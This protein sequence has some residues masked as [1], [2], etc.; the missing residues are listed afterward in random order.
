[1]SKVAGWRRGRD[2]KYP[3]YDHPSCSLFC[4]ILLCRCLTVS[5]CRSLCR[6]HY[7][8]YWCLFLSHV[9]F[10]PVDPAGMAFRDKPQDAAGLSSAFQPPS[11]SWRARSPNEYTQNVAHYSSSKLIHTRSIPPPPL[12]ART[13]QARAK[14]YRRAPARIRGYRQQPRRH[15]LGVGERGGQVR[16]V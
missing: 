14:P 16:T 5:V 4:C 12:C 7:T 1:M 6:L 13:P 2:K 8:G 15:S 11:N 9:F 3:C 10:G